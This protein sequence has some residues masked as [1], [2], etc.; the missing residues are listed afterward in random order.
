[1]ATNHTSLIEKEVTTKASFTE[2]ADSLA[3]T[4]KGFFARNT[5]KSIRF[6]KNLPLLLE[7]AE[8]IAIEGHTLKINYENGGYVA[9]KKKPAEDGEVTSLSWDKDHENKF[10]AEK[11]GCLAGMSAVLCN[12]GILRM[13]INSIVLLFTIIVVP[14]FSL[15]VIMR[16]KR[17]NKFITKGRNY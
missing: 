16:E 10:V 14:G 3:A 6:E 2:N 9:L 8:S 17:R 4:V 15:Y 7:G 5:E 13:A 11:L 12:D 1:M